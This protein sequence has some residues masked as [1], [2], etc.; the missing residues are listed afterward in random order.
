MKT[1]PIISSLVLAGCLTI[2]AGAMAEG[3]ATDDKQALART[4]KALVEL[5]QNASFLPP[6][7][8]ED[9]MRSQRDAHYYPIGLAQL[10]QKL[11]EATDP[12][13]DINAEQMQAY[14]DVLSGI[15]IQ[16][17]KDGEILWGRIQGTKYE[18]QAHDWI[19][20]K[21]KSFGLEDVRHDK[22]PSGF[23]Q[24]R[25]TTCDLEI[26]AAPGFANQQRYQFKEA[27]TAFVSATTPQG[28]IEAP[29]IYVGDGTAAE[30]QGRDISG[31]IVL[32]R[33]RTQPSAL[34]N[35]ARTAYSRVVAGE[36]GVPAGVVVW[37]DVPRT[38]QVAGRVG[39]PGGGDDIGLAAPWTTIGNDAG[40]YLRKLLDRVTPDEPV[41]VRLDVQGHMESP[42][43]RM[44]GNVYAILPGQSSDYIVIPTHV[45]GY[46]YGIH[47]N[48]A[49]V[50]L[51]LALAQH[52]A[53]IP[54]E[55]RQHGL[56]F[57]FQGD[58][59]VPGVGGTLPFVDK[60]R[61]MMEEN[62]LLVLRPEHLG[63]MR[64]LDESIYIANSNVTDPMMLLVTNRSPVLI[65]IF[66]QA[67]HLYA[68]P[69]GDLVYADP[70]ADEAAFH[71]PFN[72]L[73][74]IS[75]GW[76]LTGKFYHS[77]ADVDWG[78]INFKQVEKMA[79]GHAFIIDELF[80]LEKA[81]LHRDGHPA[82][83]KSI[84]QSN[85]LKMFMGNN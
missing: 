28:G 9:K 66:K 71:P 48:G 56:I 1:R 42:E 24:W 79:R 30:L 75:S 70:A 72:D 14:A 74:A 3:G 39:A 81:D 7:E 4:P 32:L 50:S 31:K 11:D 83:E 78:A 82:P 15:A 49:S 18:R 60:H 20:R 26:T 27:I 36:Y 58:H 5:L 59:E 21:L 77:T 29:M 51:N 68:I 65:D 47:D 63:L 85:I 76:I 67:A 13:R 53:Q 22:F 84:Y 52:Y 34:M 46:F 69:M 25:P 33:A 37:W 23:P 44:T 16:S 41:M 8:Y 35:S 54:A 12:R 40:L 2:T 55:Q 64:P 80:E 38:N 62:L 57:L 45:D 10:T 17:R 73:G 61:K 19:Y 6:Q 43:Q